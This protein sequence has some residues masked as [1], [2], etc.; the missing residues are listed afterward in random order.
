MKREKQ[1]FQI[2]DTLYRLA[3]MIKSTTGDYQL[4]RV[5]LP[6]TMRQNQGSHLYLLISGASTSETEAIQSYFYAMPSP[7]IVSPISLCLS[8]LPTSRPTPSLHNSISAFSSGRKGYSIIDTLLL[9]LSPSLVVAEGIPPLPMKL[10]E[11]I[12]KCVM[13]VDISC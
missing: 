1:L 2:H 9:S 11:K 4:S 7:I 13:N 5:S 3:S 6:L 10:I 12:H 8:L